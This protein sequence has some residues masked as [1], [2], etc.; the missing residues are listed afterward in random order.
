MEGQRRTVSPGP[1][2]IDRQSVVDV[3]FLRPST[4][5]EDRGEPSALGDQ[6]EDIRKTML[7]K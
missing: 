7:K 4:T 1:Q 2:C 6:P 5:G 3:H